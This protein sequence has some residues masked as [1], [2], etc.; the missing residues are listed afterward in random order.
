MVDGSIFSRGV[1]LPNITSVERLA[2][3]AKGSGA[4]RQL[5]PEP[6]GDERI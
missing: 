5:A 3:R 2:S 1:F 6:E 4:I